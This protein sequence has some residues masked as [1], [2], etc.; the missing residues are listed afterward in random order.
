MSGSDYK[1]HCRP[2]GVPG[3]LGSASN[4]SSYIVARV[5]A[6]LMASALPSAPADWPRRR[7]TTKIFDETWPTDAVAAGHHS[8]VLYIFI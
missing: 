8:K 7:A 6:F 5:Q 2:L 4:G 1:S 3:W